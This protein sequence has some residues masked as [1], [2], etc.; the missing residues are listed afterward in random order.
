MIARHWRG[1]AKKENAAS[2]IAHLRNDT[3]PTLKAI[4]GF[5]SASIL[6]K[7]SNEGTWFLI[8]TEWESLEAIR[9]FA[10]DEPTVAVVPPLV[11]QLMIRYDEQVEHYTVTHSTK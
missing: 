3:F 8:I 6:Q 1:L 11:Q 2:Y 5:I 7:E 10:G 9:Q 4:K